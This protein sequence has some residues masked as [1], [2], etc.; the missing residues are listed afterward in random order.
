MTSPS[1]NTAPD[2]TELAAHATWEV[3]QAF[4]GGLPQLDSAIKSKDF[5]LWTESY[6][7][8]YGPAFFNHFYEQNQKIVNGTVDGIE[9]VF[10][11]LGII[12][13]II[14]EAIQVCS[15][16]T[17]LRYIANQSTGGSLP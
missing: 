2:T 12:N 10:N 17:A 1:A 11:S 7:G 14:D 5:S 3:V 15:P 9:L 13:G 4:L 16:P 6:G 8:H